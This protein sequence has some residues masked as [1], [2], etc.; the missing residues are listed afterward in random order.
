MV[1]DTLVLDGITFQVLHQEGRDVFRCE[2]GSKIVKE[3]SL[4]SHLQTK[5]H[6]SNLQHRQLH[7]NTTI[8]VSVLKPG[9]IVYR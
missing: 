3:T 2:C 4:R 5:S 8:F 9:M 6:T 1:V 7:G